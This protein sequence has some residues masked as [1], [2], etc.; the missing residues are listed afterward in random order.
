MHVASVTAGIAN[1]KEVSRRM[2][3]LISTGLATVVVEVP[4]DQ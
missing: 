1:A 2:V 4:F 3:H